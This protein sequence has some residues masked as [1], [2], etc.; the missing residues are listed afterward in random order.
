LGKIPEDW[1]PIDALNSNDPE[2]LDQFP[3]QKPEALLERIIKTSSRKGDLVADFF[4]GCGTAVAV[5]QRLNRNWIGVDISHLAVRKIQKRIMDLYQ[6]NPEQLRKAKEGIEIDGFPRDIAS[7]HELATGAR[8]GRIKFQD[9]VIEVMMDG[10]SNPKKV[11]DG[12]YD[13]YLTLYRDAK[14]KD[15][16]LIEVKRGSVD[17]GDLRKFIYVVD[18]EKADLGVWVCFKDQVT[19]GMEAEARQA[20]YYDREA[21]GSKFPRLQIINIEDLLDG[22]TVAHPNPAMFNI[23]FKK[24]YR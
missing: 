1:W 13:G 23:T 19:R 15:V 20:G 2:R 16:V 21:F 12:G 11:G 22:K 3:T 8:K 14:K 18:H 9:W 5:A 10:V 17:V 7:A 6:D 24:A 4:C